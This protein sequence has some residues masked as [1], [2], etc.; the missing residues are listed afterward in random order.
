[1]NEFK[2][3][4]VQIQTHEKVISRANVLGM[5]KYVLVEILLLLGLQKSDKEIQE[6]VVNAQLLKQP[7]TDTSS[8]PGQPEQ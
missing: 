8:E 6:A 2:N 3:L 5:K 4:K 1:M 7:T